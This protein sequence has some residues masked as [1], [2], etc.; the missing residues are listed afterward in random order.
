VG[1][2]AQRPQVFHRRTASERRLALVAARQIA[3]TV[4]ELGR[5]LATTSLFFHTL[6]AGKVGLNATERQPLLAA[7]IPM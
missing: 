5:E 3:A 6:V 4:H 1:S 2:G 7:N